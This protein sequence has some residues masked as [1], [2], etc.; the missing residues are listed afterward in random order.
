MPIPDNPTCLLP[1]VQFAADGA[2]HAFK[3][4]AEALAKVAVP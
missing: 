1:L 4:V 2:E 3:K